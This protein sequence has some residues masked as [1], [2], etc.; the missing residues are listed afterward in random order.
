MTPSTSPLPKVSRLPQGVPKAPT[1]L[2]R[3]GREL[4]TRVV[5]EY[6]LQPHHLTLLRLAAESLDRADAARKVV[7]AEGLVVPGYRG[8]PRPHPLLL[9]ERDSRIAT[10]R[11]L[12]EIGLSEEP[13]ADPRPPRIAG[14]YA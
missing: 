9:T 3:A 1:H 2:K 4:W 10:A 14:R 8:Q 12:R 6:E 5:A 11:L 13:E 7:D